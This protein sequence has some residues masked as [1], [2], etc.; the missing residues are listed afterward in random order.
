MYR[1]D[2]QTDEGRATMRTLFTTREAAEQAIAD[3]EEGHPWE[4][5]EHKDPCSESDK[6]PV[7]W[8][9]AG[10]ALV[11]ICWQ[12]ARFW[13]AHA[14]DQ[15]KELAYWRDRARAA[16]YKLKRISEINT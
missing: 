14:Q 9:V 16:E 8:H 13:R 15:S 4:A 12:E 3:S 10:Q 5:S 6:P 1:V 2:A 11:N 7:C